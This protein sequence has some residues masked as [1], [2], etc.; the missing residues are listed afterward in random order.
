MSGGGSVGT[1]GV[2]HW[3]RSGLDPVECLKQLEGRIHDIH[4]KEIDQGEDV[5]WGTGQGRIKGI[6]KELHRLGPVIQIDLLNRL[7]VHHHTYF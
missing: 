4:I 5:V 3:V 7:I 2:G 1:A 6:L